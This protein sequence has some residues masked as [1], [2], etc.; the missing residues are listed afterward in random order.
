MDVTDLPKLNAALN[1]LST[2]LLV[3]GWLL[4]RRGRREAHRACMLTACV[5]SVAFLTSYLIYHAQVGH[6]RFV[7]PAWFRPYYLAIL[8]THLVGAIALAPLVPL[9]LVRA[10]RG[11][12]ERHRAAARWTWPVWLYVSVTG[13]VIYWLLYHQF[14]QRAAG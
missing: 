11:R 9:T 6:T 12:F 2:L 7:E 10:L 13:V 14:P 5:T 1:S 3:A 8:F 4:I